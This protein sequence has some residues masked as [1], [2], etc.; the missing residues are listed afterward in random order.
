VDTPDQNGTTP[1]NIA[2]DQ[3]QLD[4]VRLLLLAGADTAPKDKWGD[5]ALMSAEKK[6]HAAVAALLKYV[7]S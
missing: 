5:D 4:S 1:L 3:G 6:D 7:S 2:A